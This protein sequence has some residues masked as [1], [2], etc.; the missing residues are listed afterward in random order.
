MRNERVAR[1]CTAALIADALL[2][3]QDLYL[4]LHGPRRVSLQWP[5]DFLLDQRPRAHAG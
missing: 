1:V 2:T 5:D 3:L 4:R